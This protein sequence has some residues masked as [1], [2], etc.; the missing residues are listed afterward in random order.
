MAV[1]EKRVTAKYTGCPA[2][3]TGFDFTSIG[4][5]RRASSEYRI[6]RQN[7]EAI[8]VLNQYR[9]FRLNCIQTSLTMLRQAGLPDRVFVSARLKRLGSIYRKLKR[10][11]MRNIRGSVSEMD[12]IIGFRVIC[13][14]FNDAVLLSTSLEKNLGARMKD[15]LQ[16]LHTTGTG[17]RSI[18][19]V[20]R[21]NQPFGKSTVSSR[22]E[23]QVRTWYQHLWAC[24]SE[25]HGE[26]A[27]EGYPDASSKEMEAKKRLLLVSHKLKDWEERNPHHEQHKLLDISD[28]Y[29]M[30]VAWY[31][32][33]GTLGF[34]P[35]MADMEKAADQL[36]Y[37][38]TLTSIEPL[39]LVGVTSQKNLR[40]LL[41]NTHPKFMSRSSLDP[42]YWMPSDF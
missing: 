9:R 24:W 33:D 1:G 30:A 41:R 39:L 14:S 15:Y 11:E 18:H 16:G 27:K 19:A 10:N 35:F 7:P 5:I 21:L 32:D 28:L 26:R 12:D 40:N 6:N 37:L 34:D 36:S 20:L 29:N 3:R 2:P 8:D 42:Q 31:R 17:Y 23:I 38:E 13:S 4:D 25:S 22:F